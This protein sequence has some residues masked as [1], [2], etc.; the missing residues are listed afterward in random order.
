[1]DLTEYM[2]EMAHLLMIDNNCTTLY[3]NPS[4]NVGVCFRQGWIEISVDRGR[5]YGRQNNIP[6]VYWQG[7]IICASF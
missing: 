2:F 5:T 7:I 3:R 1:M 6:S 4:V